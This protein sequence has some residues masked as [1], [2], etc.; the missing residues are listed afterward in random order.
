MADQFAVVLN[1]EGGIDLTRVP[2]ID[3][4]L[5]RDRRINERAWGVLVKK[6]REVY[7][8][9]RATPVSG[10]ANEGSKWK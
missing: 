1:A 9:L 7:R 3:I 4:P 6:D 2:R 5:P 10:V 8:H